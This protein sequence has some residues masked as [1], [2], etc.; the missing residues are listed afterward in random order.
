MTTKEIS[1]GRP[2]YKSEVEGKRGKWKN[3]FFPEGS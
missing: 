1:E 2:G 3:V